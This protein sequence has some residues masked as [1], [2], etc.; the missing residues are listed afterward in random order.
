M[1]GAG[2]SLIRR[3][4]TRA[5]DLAPLFFAVLRYISAMSL[6]GRRKGLMD[7]EERL[8]V[9]DSASAPA[10]GYGPPPAPTDAADDWQQVRKARPADYLLPISE[11]W[12]EH[13]PND[14]VPVAL[15][16]QFPRIVNLVAMQWEDRRACPAYFEELLMDR[17]GGR[18]GFPAEVRRDL[19]RLRNYWYSRDTTLLE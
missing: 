13:L 8:Q 11:R 14:I 1:A 7:F 19:S 10:T 16:T 3:V 5:R 9:R 12:V 17:R 15:A 18:R 6:Y 2:T 4:V